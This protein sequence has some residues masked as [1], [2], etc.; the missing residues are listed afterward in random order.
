MKRETDWL[1]KL[2]ME[3]SVKLTQSQKVAKWRR[4]NPEKYQENQRRY[5][6]KMKTERPDELA[7]RYRKRNY[8]SK[9]GITLEI[10]EEMLEK[11]NGVCYICGNKNV[12][13]KHLAVDHCH[14][15]GKVRKLLCN[16][17]NLTVEHIENSLAPYERYIDYIE[18]HARL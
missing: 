12:A 8:K 15:S 7:L 14:K 10:F 16:P 13:N 5:Q 3:E 6:E 2:A 11:Q 9:Y 1:T 18:D 4:D 17:C